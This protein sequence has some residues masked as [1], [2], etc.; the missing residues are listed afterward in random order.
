MVPNTIT[1][2][3]PFLV[4]GWLENHGVRWGNIHGN[5]FPEKSGKSGKLY[6]EAVFDAEGLS[7]RAV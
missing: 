7:D 1:L 4:V 5:Y 3:P 6:A 2:K